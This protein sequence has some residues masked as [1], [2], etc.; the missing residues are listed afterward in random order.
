MILGITKGST[1]SR[2]KN[3]FREKLSAARNN[4]QLRAKICLAYDII[5]NNNFYKECEKDVFKINDLGIDIICGYY[6]TIIG[7]CYN[8]INIIEKNPNIL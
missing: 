8:L 3:S 6:Y 7:D 2:T 4:D 5:V 1:S